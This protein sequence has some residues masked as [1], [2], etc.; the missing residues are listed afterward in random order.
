MYVEE[1]KNGYLGRSTLEGRKFDDV[2][3][4]A[5]CH[6]VGNIQSA[7]V[8]F[9][10]GQKFHFD[11]DLSHNIMWISAR[12]NNQHAARCRTVPQITFNHTIHDE[13]HRPKWISSQGA[14]TGQ[15]GVLSCRSLVASNRPHAARPRLGLFSCSKMGP[16]RLGLQA[17]CMGPGKVVRS[18]QKG[19]EDHSRSRIKCQGWQTR[20]PKAILHVGT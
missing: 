17:L 7:Q 4:R 14:R 20:N 18:A 16:W 8:A 10:T 2:R 5:T 12:T 6:L 3:T 19:H 13:G 9:A 1:A 11:T 15:A